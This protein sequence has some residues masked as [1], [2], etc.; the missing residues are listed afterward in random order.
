MVCRR[1]PGIEEVRIYH[2]CGIGE[3]LSELV[4]LI[5]PAVCQVE[6]ACSA[7]V[8]EHVCPALLLAHRLYDLLYGF[9][10]VAQHVVLVVLCSG[11]TYEEASV[12]FFVEEAASRATNELVVFEVLHPLA[13]HG[14]VQFARLRLLLLI[15][16]LIRDVHYQ[17]NDLR[18]YFNVD[19]A[20]LRLLL[21]PECLK[22]LLPV[23]YVANVL[24]DLLW[25]GL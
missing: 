8:L 24:L 17:V 18:A 23:L 7:Q 10:Q 15:V 2:L 19:R 13:P 25:H 20:F 16:C 21:P 11:G 6:D 14:L 9:L 12:F 5:V 4:P 1:C 22:V 3:D